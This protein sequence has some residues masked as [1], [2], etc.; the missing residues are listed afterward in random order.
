MVLF[1]CFSDC[2]LR[3]F[4]QL[5]G[6]QQLSSRLPLTANVLQTAP[7]TVTNT[8]L[9]SGGGEINLANDS[10]T[11]LANVISSADISVTNAASPNPVA[12]GSNISYAQIV[13]DIGPSAG[14]NATLVATIPANTTFVSM[15]APAGWTCTVGSSNVVCSIVSLVGGT[16][17]TFSLIVKVNAGTANGT[18]ITEIASVSSTANDPNSAN[19]T[20]T[21]NTVVGTAAGGELTVTNSASPNPV[22][23]GSNITYTQVVTNTGSVAATG[24]SFSEA[25][26]ANTIFLSVTPPA[27]WTCAGFPAMPCSN[28]GVAAG[29]TGTFTVVYT[30]NALTSSG[31]V[32]TDTVTVNA[33][34]QGFG[35][36][37]ATATDVVASGGQADL[38]LTTV[39]TPTTVISGNNITYTQTVTNNGPAAASTVSFTEPIPANTTFVSVS[40]PA[41]WTCTITASVTCTNPS[42]AAGASADIIVV[43]NLA[44]TV[45]VATITANSSVSSSGTTDP[46]PSNN[47]TTVVTN[48][49][50]ACNLTVTNSGSPS[51]VAAGANIAYTQVVT[52]SGPSN[53]TSATFTEAFPA[54]TTFVSLI[55]VPAGWTCTTA[56]S[57]SCTNPSVAP[58]SS[59]TFPVVVTV[60]A[61]TGAGTII[62]D[63]AT[64]ASA[65][66]DTNPND[67][68]A[69]VNIGVAT[70]GQADL[71]VTNSA[72]PNPVNA[73]QNVTY[74][75]T[76]TNG[77]PAAASTITL[78][79]TVPANTTFVS[80]TGPAGWTCTSSVPYTC[81]IPTLAVNATANFTFV[82]KVNANVASGSTVSDTATVGATTPDPNNLNNNASASVQV[83]DSADLSV[84]NSASPVPVIANTNI[85]YTQVVTNAGPSVATNASFSEAV[86]A[87]TTFISLTPIPPGWACIFGATITCTNSSFAP[88]T[89]SF[90]VVVKVNVAGNP[91]GTVI[92]DTAT[93]NS[94]TTD[95]NA[96]NNSATATDVVATAL[97]ADLI[98]SNSASPVSVSA[99]SNITYSQSVTNNG[100]AAATTVSFTQT[101]PPNTNFQSISASAGWTCGTQPPVGGTGTI[102]CTIASLALSATANFTLVLQVNAGT[103]SGTNIAET[104]MAT[105][106]NIIPGLT[107]N[108]AIGS[109]VVA[110]ANSADMA[111]VKTATP[112]PTVPQGDTLTYT[113]AITNNGPASATNVTVTDALPATLTYLSR[114]PPDGRVFRSQRDG[115]LSSGNHGERVVL[116]R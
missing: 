109:V 12:A 100:P 55:P 41:G 102:T 78:S 110:N 71:G 45:A 111:I 6:E 36:N 51:P 48:V 106:T 70:A 93:I 33:G 77:G 4:R 76:V 74:S 21:V 31:T 79:E 69:T 68:F 60:N 34:N 1:N 8:A 103:A 30:V 2:Q 27:G 32:I 114:P 57:I 97:Q 89:A 43:V 116:P 61:G 90:P 23:A 104:A 66:S 40:A 56:G 25:T 10:S 29:S 16:S 20:A 52:N 99:G 24:A 5:G 37:S 39:A 42:V 17:A 44:P 49:R 113:L 75:Q 47:N 81:T 63:T 98:T 50:M 86:P 15:A 115:D 53:C 87:N 22:I 3:S 14:D 92:T 84:T 112:G 11:D 105:A 94:S 38:A 101:T 26:P 13:T 18:V 59:S 7:S 85:T 72:S 107:T 62:T 65:T 28:P 88:G 9:V 35:P 95:P 64:A 83:A 91:P 19:N 82:V 108:S 80:L 67:N 46:T 73:G 58:G 96:G 54:N